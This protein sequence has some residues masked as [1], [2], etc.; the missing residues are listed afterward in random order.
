MSDSRLIEEA[1]GLGK[2]GVKKWKLSNYIDDVALS[3]GALAGRRC[4]QGTTEPRTVGQH[5]GDRKR[6]PKLRG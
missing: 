2:K 1:T 3:A 5:M 6:M 4:D